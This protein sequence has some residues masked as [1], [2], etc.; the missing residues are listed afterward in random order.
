MF[1][2]AVGNM[3]LRGDGKSNIYQGDCCLIEKS[4]KLCSHKPDVGLIN[5]PFSEAGDNL[6]N[7]DY[8]ILNILDIVKKGGIVIGI[9][10]P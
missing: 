5:P 6:K 8:I 7:L 4:K 2:L 1:T 10:P 9:L 3:I